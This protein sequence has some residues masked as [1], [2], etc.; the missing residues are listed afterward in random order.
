MDKPMILALF[1]IAVISKLL[2]YITT[3]TFF[4]SILILYFIYNFTLSQNQLMLAL[5][6][7]YVEIKND[8]NS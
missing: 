2:G 4:I 5:A 3:D 8:K 7:I 6:S 1:L